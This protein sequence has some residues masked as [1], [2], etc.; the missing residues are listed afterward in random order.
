[1]KPCPTIFRSF[2][3]E[4]A[5]LGMQQHYPLEYDTEKPVLKWVDC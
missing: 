5:Q 2:A 3:P 4:L 1:M